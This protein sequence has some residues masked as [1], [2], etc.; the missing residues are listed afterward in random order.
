MHKKEHKEGE[1]PGCTNYPDEKGTESETASAVGYALRLC[2]TNY[3]D[4]KGTE[5]MVKSSTP[6]RGFGCT[7][8]PDE[9]GTERFWSNA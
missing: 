5:S 2:C 3:P 6:S 4:E 1:R 8:Y 9:K 7:N